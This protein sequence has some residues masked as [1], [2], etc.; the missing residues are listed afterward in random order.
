[1]ALQ[2]VQKSQFRKRHALFLFRNGVIFLNLNWDL[3]VDKVKGEVRKEASDVFS[4][5]FTVNEAR[6]D[7]ASVIRAGIAFS[8]KHL[9]ICRKSK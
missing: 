4:V 8:I 3:L 9:E 2:P 6:S 1:M 7:Y 5:D